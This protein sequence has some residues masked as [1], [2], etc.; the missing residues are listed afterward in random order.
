MLITSS[1]SRCHPIAHTSDDFLLL[2]LF[3]MF[4]RQ[5]QSSTLLRHDGVW[6]PL[7]ST[8]FRLLSPDS[9]AR[10]TLTEQISGRTNI[11]PSYC[12]LW[13]AAY[14][15]SLVADVITPKPTIAKP[16]EPSDLISNACCRKHI[17]PIGSGA[18]LR[19]RCPRRARLAQ[20][21]AR[22]TDCTAKATTRRGSNRQVAL[23]R[24]R[25]R[26]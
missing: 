14:P 19:R 7:A 13:R 2:L 22:A 8:D 26:G 17:A 1:L 4:L 16:P 25:N 18:A 15:P 23:K 6:C 9:Q 20:S 11:A 10:R 12:P 21:E 3:C 24:N 5:T